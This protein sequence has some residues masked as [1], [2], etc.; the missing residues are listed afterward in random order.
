MQEIKT[1]LDSYISSRNLAKT[2][3]KA[4]INLDD[5]LRECIYA[6][7]Q[8]KQAIASDVESI[9]REELVK[10]VIGKMQNWYEIERNGETS[11]K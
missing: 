5:L 10:R 11:Q 4:Y 2:K 6:K 1:L 9:K 3:D 7:Q 8:F